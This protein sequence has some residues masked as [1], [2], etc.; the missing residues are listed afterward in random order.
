[1]T[2]LFV[3]L[4]GSIILSGC[5]DLQI[6]ELERDSDGL[7][8]SDRWEHFSKEFQGTELEC[9]ELATKDFWEIC[10]GIYSSHCNNVWEYTEVFTFIGDDGKEYCGMSIPK[11]YHIELIS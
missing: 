1:M 10:P 6:G 8:A 2:A 5:V 3:L 11:D 4:I 7:I 9:L